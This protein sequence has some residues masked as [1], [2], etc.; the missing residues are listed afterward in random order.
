MS[1]TVIKD[2]TKALQ[3]LLLNQLNPAGSSTAQVSLVPPGEAL[4]TG[5]GVNL[6]LY[7]VMESPATKNEPWP[8]NRVTPP[9]K[10]PALGLE[11]SYL[12]TPFATIPDA[13]SPSGDD[14]HTMLGTAML[15]F[16]EHAILNDVH[17][18]GFDADTVLSADLL[19]SFE[20]VKIRLATTSLEEL[21]KIWAT[22]NQ[23]YRLSVA[24]DVSLVIVPPSAPAP[25]GLGGVVTSTGIRI[26]Q[27]SSPSLDSLTPPSGPLAHVG[28]GG[29]LASNPLTIAGSGMSMPGKTPQVEFGGQPATIDAAPP[30]TD[31]S[32]A[33]SMPI[34]VGAGPAV[35]VQVAVAGMAGAPLTFLVTPWV[36]G[37]TPVRTALDASA[38]AASLALTLTGQGFTTTP[39]G[40]RFDGPTGTASA[41]AN[42]TTTVTTFAGAPV[43]GTVTVT[44][45]PGL[46]NGIY[47]VRVVL[48]DAT[49]SVSNSRALAVIPLLT[50]PIGLA[51]VTIGGNQVHQLTLNGARLTG[52]D[53][54]VLIDGAVYAAGANS[55]AAQMI[56]ALGRLLS[57]GPHNVG[58]SVDGSASHLVVLQAP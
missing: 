12:L 2:V 43:D 15:A 35:D 28:A 37:M 4:P 7:R 48:N 10:V 55:N 49:A 29:V 21:S 18:P 20:Q 50:A 5:L 16:H 33:I 56:F 52:G 8:G 1:A 24:Y 31:S 26:A 23:P 34:T 54:R 11:L 17:I 38:G 27:W 14:A 47:N 25:S 6:Y 40:V 53:V 39:Q 13:T 58:V 9:A 36:A 30:A 41:T 22:I 3:A 51:A 19:N 44:I 46:A 32:L 45:P 42:V 57:S